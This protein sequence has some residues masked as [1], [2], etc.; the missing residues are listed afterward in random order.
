[1]FSFRRRDECLRRWRAAF[2]PLRRLLSLLVR[3]LSSRHLSFLAS[4]TLPILRQIAYV[5]V[6][7]YMQHCFSAPFVPIIVIITA[8]LLNIKFSASRAFIYTYIC[9][10]VRGVR[11]RDSLGSRRHSTA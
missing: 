9:I 8:P 11:E 5:N 6:H 2:L 3:V 4:I 7:I 10:Y 1:M